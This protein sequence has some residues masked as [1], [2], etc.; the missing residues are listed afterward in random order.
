MHWSARTSVTATTA[1][2]TSRS[3]AR[4]RCR[5]TCE[6]GDLRDEGPAPLRSLQ[7]HGRNDDAY[8]EPLVSLEDPETK[9]YFALVHTT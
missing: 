2:S 6:R 1:T 4:C 7:P 3:L 8:F 9:L 5:S